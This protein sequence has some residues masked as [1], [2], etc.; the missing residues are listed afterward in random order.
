M[1]PLGAVATWRFDWAADR[2]GVPVI[3][4]AQLGLQAALWA[5][6]NGRGAVVNASAGGHGSGWTS[7]WTSALGVAL[8]LDFLDP[9]LA[10]EA[11]NEIHLQRTAL[12][13]EYGWTHLDG[14]GNAGV[15][16]LSDRA[17]R[18]GLSL[19]F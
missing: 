3:F 14:F 13:A 1:I 16:V 15:L 2:Y 4:Y 9:S 17:W 7:G 11:F 10:R 8:A 12:F 19:E 5:A 18:F 6:F